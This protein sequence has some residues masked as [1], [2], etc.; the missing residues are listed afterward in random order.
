[1]NNSNDH[2]THNRKIRNIANDTMNKSVAE[3]IENNRR[4]YVPF[5][6]NTRVTDANDT[7]STKRI[8]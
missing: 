6:P 5:T 4:V 2:F 7:K 8:N 1:M 3:L